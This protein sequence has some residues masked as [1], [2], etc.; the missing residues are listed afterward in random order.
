MKF[1]RSE[2]ALS[3]IYSAALILMIVAIMGSTVLYGLS[4]HITAATNT[5][6]NKIDNAIQ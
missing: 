1:L 6:T 3:Q 4:K 5:A 2:K